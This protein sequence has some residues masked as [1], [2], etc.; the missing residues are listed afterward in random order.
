VLD[1]GLRPAGLRRSTGREYWYT[2]GLMKWSKLLNKKMF[3]EHVKGSENR[4]RT[5]IGLRSFQIEGGKTILIE[6]EEVSEQTI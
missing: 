3:E 4:V 6:D 2:V 1:Q 5:S